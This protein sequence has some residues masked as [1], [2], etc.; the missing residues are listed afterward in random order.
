MVGVALASLLVFSLT[1]CATTSNL[2]ALEGAAL[3][4]SN[5]V[6]KEFTAGWGYIKTLDDWSKATQ[7]PIS[8]SWDTDWK[9]V[10]EVTGTKCNW[11]KDNVIL[12][13]VEVECQLYFKTSGSCRLVLTDTSTAPSS[14]ASVQ[15]PSSTEQL[16]ATRPNISFCKKSKNNT[17]A[18]LPQGDS[19]QPTEVHASPL[20]ISRA[21]LRLGCKL[22]HFSEY[23]VQQISEGHYWIVTQLRTGMNPG[24][25]DVRASF[26]LHIDA[27]NDDYWI[28][29][30]GL[31]WSTVFGCTAGQEVHASGAEVNDKL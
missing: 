15:L 14:K 5:E 22:S 27:T 13:N 29:A 25:T 18:P 19:V 26:G 3:K 8:V 10:G 24:D 7:A 28:E 21:L 6:V 20:A 2:K 4:Y 11:A 1:S 16:R 17:S 30:D 9:P 12:G 23:K 31:G